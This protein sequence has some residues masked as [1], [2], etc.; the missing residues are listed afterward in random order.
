MTNEY[1]KTMTEFFRN[2]DQSVATSP[3]ELVKAFAKYFVDGDRQVSVKLPSDKIYN[4]SIVASET[5]LS[6]LTK[7]VPLVA[8][9]T[10]LTHFRGQPHLFYDYVDSPAS[11]GANKIDTK[12]Y[13]RCPDLN[14]LGKW[15]IDCKPL[16]EQ[17][18]V[19]YFPDILMSQY[20]ENRYD[21]TGNTDEKEHSIAH[22]CD[23]IIENRKITDII[24]GAILKSKL[25]RP[26]ISLDIPYIENV[27]MCEFSKIT[28]DE[29]FSLE[30]FRN[31]LRHKFLDLKKA[32]SGESFDAEMEKIGIE[33][34]EGVRQLGSDFSAMK[35]KSAFQATGGL[36]ASVTAILVAVDGAVFDN[37]SKIIGSGGGLFILGKALE[38]H[39]D[40]KKRL[41]ESPYYYLWLLSKR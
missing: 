38:D 27:N 23:L 39:I 6:F 4:I 41:Q 7:R 5:S 21:D 25:V 17:G 40:K 11:W 29:H 13:I 30:R 9:T 14:E 19:F 15:L 33:L 12:C 37:L 28:L 26:I 36:I 22:L 20:T 2:V 34:S 35:R 8:D 24:N 10:V 32:E 1:A 16:L 18:E 31:F 3:L